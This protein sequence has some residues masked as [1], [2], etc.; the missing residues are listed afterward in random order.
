MNIG[1]NIDKGKRFNFD[2]S[3]EGGNRV[4]VD[5]DIRREKIFADLSVDTLETG[6]LVVLIKRAGHY[7]VGGGYV[8]FIV[9]LCRL[10]ELM[11]FLC[12]PTM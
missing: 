12:D 7:R 6:N 9:L 10:C 4:H 8:D 3:M 5:A 1:S 11:I 2:V